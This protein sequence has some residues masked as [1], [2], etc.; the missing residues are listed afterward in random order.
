VTPATVVL[1]H[2]PLT[3]AAAWGDLPGA[4]SAHGV[5]CVVPDVVDD[6]RPPFATRYVAAVAQALTA[7]EPTPPTLLVAHSGAGPLLPQIGFAR[8]A[9]HRA[10]A[11]YVFLDAALPRPGRPASRLDLLDEEDPDVAAEVGEALAGGGSFPAWTAADLAADLPDP[12]ARAAALAALRPRGLDFF[13]EPLPYP[14]D[15]PDAPVGYL[16]TSAAYDRLARSAAQRGW[17]VVRRGSG[18]F[19]ALADPAG[20]AAALLELVALL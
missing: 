6:D 5:A 8:R 16:R 19:A 12:A 14:G 10:P 17:P 20:T 1:L 9:V 15:W 18:H 7:A 13:R 3:S 11:G 4:L 2:S